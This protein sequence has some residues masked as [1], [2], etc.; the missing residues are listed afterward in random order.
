M[1]PLRRLWQS[2]RRLNE[3]VIYECRHCGTSV[4]ST[5]DSCPACCSEEIAKIDL[6]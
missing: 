5:S 2:I 4:E 1:N 6:D 3:G